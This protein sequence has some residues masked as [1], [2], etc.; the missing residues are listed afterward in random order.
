MRLRVLGNTRTF[1]PV[2]L[3]LT[4][5]RAVVLNAA[6]PNVMSPK[7]KYFFTAAIAGLFQFGIFS[8]AAQQTN[9]PVQLPPVTVEGV[10]PAPIPQADSSAT[11]TIS[12]DEVQPGEITSVRDLTA[13]EPNL[14]VFG[15]SDDRTPKFSIRGLRENSFGVGEPVLGMYVDDVPYFDLSSRAMPLYDLAGIQIA[16]GEQGTLY[17]ASG[18]GGVMNITTRQPVNVWHGSGTLSF[19]DYDARSYQVGAGGALIKDQLY[20]NL[21]GLYGFRDGYVHNL[22][23][24]DYPDTQNTLSGR[25]EL[26]WTPSEPWKIAFTAAGERFHDGFIPT[27]R[28]GVET[29]PSPPFPAGSV[30]PPDPSPFAVN[31]YLNG[32]DD[33]ADD[34]QALKISYDAGPALFSSVTTHR[35]WK[36]NL[37]QDFS[38]SDVLPVQG[39]TQP[40]IEQWGEEVHVKSPDSADKLKWLAGFYFLDNDVQNNSGSTGSPVSVTESDGQTYALFGQGTYTLLE[41][42]DLTAGLRATFDDRSIH[43]SVVNATNG[44][45]PVNSSADF[46]AVQPKF[47]VAWHFTPKT[48]VYASVAQGYQSGGFN[49]FLNNNSYGPARSWEYELGLKSSCDDNKYTTHAALFYTETGGYQVI[50]ESP[51]DP[52]VAN[53][54][55]A[56]RAVSYGAELELTAKPMEALELGAAAGYTSATYKNFTDTSSGVPLQLAGQPISFVPEFTADLSAT[57]H[58]PWHAYIRGDVLGIGRYHLDDTGTPLAGPTVQGSYELVNLQFGFETKYFEACLFARNVFDRHYFSNAENFGAG[59]AAASGF[60]SL[61]LQPGDPATWGVAITARF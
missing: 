16:R 12:G 49:P 52:L 50:R 25:A 54:L 53:L 56:H 24:N 10:A 43:G 3:F 57:C 45:A 46:S 18:V 21:S 4:N 5:G 23:L 39:F 30:A 41:K 11:T 51:L 37:L 1:A 38:F 19:G 27:Y 60:N 40:R 31:R 6:A 2:F 28:P 36:Q 61:I 8:L 59:P 13:Q 20:L 48:E 55:N 35:D 29:L 42:L 32:W 26:I 7:M 44:P 17:G 58:L 33:A 22:A 14:T 47:A 9:E 15:A 34:S